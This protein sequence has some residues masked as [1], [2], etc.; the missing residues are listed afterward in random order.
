MERAR[1]AN[2]LASKE[3]RFKIESG[4]NIILAASQM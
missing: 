4:V 3:V 1:K 2:N